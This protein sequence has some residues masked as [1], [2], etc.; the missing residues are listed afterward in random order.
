MNRLLAAALVLGSASSLL[1]C[2][3]ATTVD[4]VGVDASSPDAS[5]VD[6]NPSPTDAGVDVGGIE[7]PDVPAVPVDAPVVALDTP[8]DAPSGGEGACNNAPDLAVLAMDTIEPIIERCAGTTFGRE[9]ATTN[10]IRDMSGLSAG[11][12]MCFGG[13]VACVVRACFTECIGG[14]SSPACVRCRDENCTPAFVTCSG[15]SP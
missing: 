13:S 7:L 4:D 5:R 15:V 11:C 12:S 1:G 10:C 2:P 14:A 9:P 6:T 8:G 3:A